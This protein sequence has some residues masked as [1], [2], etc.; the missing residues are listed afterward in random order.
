MINISSSKNPNQKNQPDFSSVPTP[1]S[2][3]TKMAK[4]EESEKKVS[5]D[6]C[7]KKKKKN[8]RVFNDY[9]FMISIK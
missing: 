7:S 9:P 2:Q 3:R 8:L 4:P 6:S 1:K 5:G